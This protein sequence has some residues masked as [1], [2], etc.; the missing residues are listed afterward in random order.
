MRYYLNDEAIQADLSNVQ[1]TD[2]GDRF[3]VKSTH[4]D[5]SVTT[6]TGVA[7]REGDKV[8]IS[9]DG[10]QVQLD[11]RLHRARASAGVDSGELRAPMPGQIVDVLV[12]EGQAVTKGQKVAVL[13]AMKT[14]QPF[15]AP[16]DG[17]VHRILSNRGDQ[18]SDGQVV[19]V[20]V[21]E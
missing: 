13:E 18:V 5:G 15:L 3:V 16:F 11:T 20:I 19:V 2:L 7:I 1:V 8:L 10:I 12:E 4:G 9:F 21:K 14:Q 17:L 6:R